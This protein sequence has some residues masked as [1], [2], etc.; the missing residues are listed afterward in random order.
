M[1]QLFTDQT[2]RTFNFQ[3]QTWKHKIITNLDV[4]QFKTSR[5]ASQLFTGQT[6]CTFY[7]QDQTL[8]HKIITNLAALDFNCFHN[9]DFK[10]ILTILQLS[11][12]QIFYTINF[13]DQT[14]KHKIIAILDILNCKTINRVVQILTDQT[15]GEGKTTYIVSAHFCYFSAR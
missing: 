6:F 14:W 5:R 1:T 10:S 9:S 3:D 7:F 2:F 4:L 12:D 13:Y 8:K 15:L 11:T